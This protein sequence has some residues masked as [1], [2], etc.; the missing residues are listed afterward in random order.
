MQHIDTCLGLFL[1]CGDGLTVTANGHKDHWLGASAV[2]V[3]YSDSPRREGGIPEKLR[4]LP[5]SGHTVSYNQSPQLHPTT[6]EH[7]KSGW[8]FGCK[9]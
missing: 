2:C 1:G 8:K 6:N 9:T 3:C 5:R 4:F 7:I